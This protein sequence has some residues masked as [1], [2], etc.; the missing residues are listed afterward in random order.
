[1]PEEINR[2]LTDHAASMFFC[3]T[4]IAVRNLVKAG[5]SGETVQNVGDVMYDSAL[6]YGTKSKSVA[7]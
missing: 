3:S 4:I 1:M 2:I 7:T 5:I 6:Y